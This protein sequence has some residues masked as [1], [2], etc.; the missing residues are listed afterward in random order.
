MEQPNQCHLIAF[1]GTQSESGVLLLLLLH[2][3]EL[4]LRR[5]GLLRIMPVPEMP[6]LVLQSLF[7]RIS[8]LQLPLHSAATTT[9]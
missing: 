5:S 1:N 3:N 4:F 8:L 7:P 6:L 9:A 2:P